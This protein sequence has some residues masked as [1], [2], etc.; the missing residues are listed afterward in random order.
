M[1]EPSPYILEARRETF[2]QEVAERSREV[3]VVLDFW[4]AWCQPCRMLT[5]VLERLAR[6]YAGR[7]LLVKVNTEEMP[8][9]AQAFGVTSIPAVYALRDGQILDAFAGVQPEATIRAF[10]DR[11]LPS[12]A[13]Q[14]A[15]EAVRLEAEDPRGAIARYTAALGEDPNL[16]AARIGLGR[17]YLSLNRPDEARAQIEALER[18]GFLEPEAETLKA[19]LV[20]QAGGTE[21]G[22]V[23]A[24]RAAL[25]A[26]PGDR[27]SQFQLAEALAAAGQ[28][29]E[30]LEL[31]LDLVE[32]DRAGVGEEARKLM[33][34]VF[35]TLPAD[36]PLAADFRRRL[37]FVL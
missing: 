15:A 30:A 34:A 12:N 27:H 7:F 8:E 26:N 22:G 1:S 5:P 28:Y 36:D 3:P 6:E 37:S 14:L 16:A 21:A 23:A 11:L 32:R 19:R 33:L 17:V 18:R 29:A 2:Q 4:A 24:A 13:E 25:A 20:L 31:G 10:L 35:Q 9:M